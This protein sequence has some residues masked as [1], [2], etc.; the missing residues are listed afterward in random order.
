M[1]IDKAPKRISLP[2]S[3]F[4][5]FGER[6]I[7]LSVVDE[8]GEDVASV[9]DYSFAKAKR[10]LVAEVVEALRTAKERDR[11]HQK[12]MIATEEGTVVSI[13]FDAGWHY[14]F[15][16]DGGSGSVCCGFSSFDEARRAAV[17]HVEDAFGGIKW[18]TWQGDD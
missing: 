14:R 16:R 18:K 7:L 2:V 3:S 12:A 4:R 5:S 9:L 1:A 17:R 6:S 11:N 13:G 10:R 15:W 8:K